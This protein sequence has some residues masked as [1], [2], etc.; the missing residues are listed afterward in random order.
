[1]ITRSKRKQIK[2]MKKPR[3]RM[4]KLKEKAK[5]HCFKCGKHGHKR[6]QCPDSVCPLVGHE[7]TIA[8]K[9]HICLYRYCLQYCGIKSALTIVYQ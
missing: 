2:S 8:G 4:M 5:F 1:M 6:P 9:E 3:E 7:S